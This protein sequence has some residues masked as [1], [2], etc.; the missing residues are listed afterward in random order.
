MWNGLCAEDGI[1]LTTVDRQTRDGTGTGGGVETGGGKEVAAVQY[2]QVEGVEIKTSK[3][4]K[5]LI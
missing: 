5:K 4:R 3:R 1:R 2:T